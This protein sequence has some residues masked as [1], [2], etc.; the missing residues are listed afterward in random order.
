MSVT[1]LGNQEY[2]HYVELGP[3]VTAVNAAEAFCQ[4]G[5]VVLSPCAWSIASQDRYDV[6]LMEDE[7]HVRVSH[8]QRN[9]KTRRDALKSL[10]VSA[11][12]LDKICGPLAKMCGQLAK[13]DVGNLIIFWHTN[14]YE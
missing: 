12:Q 14:R 10:C 4:S 8:I 3:A 13:M 1:F 6:V 9:C 5:Y 7:K 2:R 11:R